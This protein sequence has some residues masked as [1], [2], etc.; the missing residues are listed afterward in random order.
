MAKIK[1]ELE[2]TPGQNARLAD[3][4]LLLEQGGD[5]ARAPAP[6]LEQSAA[7][8]EAAAAPVSEPGVSYEQL[9]G[10]CAKKSAISAQQS[11]AVRTLLK[12]YGADKLS[13]IAPEN[14][15]ALFAEVEA[16]V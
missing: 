9:R 12:K 7:T 6:E 16:I 14:Y 3:F 15:G 4:L 13:A 8:P 10:A 2:L 5:A 1:I 11:E